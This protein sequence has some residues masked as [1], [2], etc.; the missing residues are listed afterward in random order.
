M[1]DDWRVVGAVLHILARQMD[2]KA[3]NVSRLADAQG[4]PR[5]T[6]RRL[7]VKAAERGLVEL[8][9]RGVVIREERLKAVAAAV[10]RSVSLTQEV[11][12][13]AQ[14]LGGGDQQPN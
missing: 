1:A 13:K 6:M 14:E 2:G 7:L 5:E 3:T 10:L 4:I 8:G 9:H 11:A 12:Q